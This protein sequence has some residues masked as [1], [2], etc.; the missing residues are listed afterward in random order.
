ME[1]TSGQGVSAT[2]PG[3]IDRWNWG[4][5]LL[6]WIWGIG[7]NTDIAFLMFVP[8]VFF[9]VPFVLG[10]KGS[11]WAWR[12][13]RWDSIDQFKA[14]QRNWARWG[15]IVL[16]LTAVSFVGLLFLIANSFK[17]SDAYKLAIARLEKSQEV[18]QLVGLPY[19]PAC[20]WEVFK[21]PGRAAV[22]VSRLASAARKAMAQFFW[23]PRGILGYGRSNAWSLNKMAP[24]VVSI[25]ATIQPGS[26]HGR[27]A[28]ML[29]SVP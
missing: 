3:E 1:N 21:C 4:A 26:Q 14:V 9:V 5:F 24:D 18:A 7:N 19:Q 16:V 20:R 29:R 11:S 28:T 23:K 8:L 15:V 6:N 25:S 2:V 10:A 27:R 17:S 22:Q 12:N 13:K